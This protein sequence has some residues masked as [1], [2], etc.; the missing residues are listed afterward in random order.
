MYVVQLSDQF[1]DWFLIVSNVGQSLRHVG[2]CQ[3][4]HLLRKPCYMTL[5]TQSPHTVLPI[6]RNIHFSNMSGLQAIMMVVIDT[7][8]FILLGPNYTM[9]K[10]CLSCNASYFDIS[11]ASPSHNGKISWFFTQRHWRASQ[12]TL[13]LQRHLWDVSL[14]TNIRTGDQSTGPP[15]GHQGLGPAKALNSP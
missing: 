1:I 9:K 7:A 8:H 6:I 11:Y 10:T 13:L 4:A 15:L 12:K 2:Y 14:W 5:Q 3:L